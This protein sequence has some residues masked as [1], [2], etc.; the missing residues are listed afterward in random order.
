VRI[1]I[2]NYVWDPAA[3][4]PEALLGRFPTLTGWSEAVLSAGVAA[5]PADVVHV[6]SVLHP[7]R[8][9]RLRAMLPRRTGSS[10]PRGNRS[11]TGGGRP[12]CRRVCQSSM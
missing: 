2:V 5:D 1:A 12:W 4:T 10:S 7:R 9:R 8:V 3:A 6:N 11:R